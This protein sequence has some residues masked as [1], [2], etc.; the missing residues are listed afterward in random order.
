MSQEPVRK[1]FLKEFK[2]ISHGLSTYEDLNL[3]VSHLAEGTTRTFEAI[4]CCIMLF[5]DTEN[6]LFPFGC[7]GI[8]EK[9]LEK[10]P[11]CVDDKYSAFVRGEPVF[12]EDIRS[13]P[14]IKYPDEALEE[15]IV[16]ILSIPIKF[17]GT[18]IGLIRIYNGEPK[19][20][21]EEDVDALRVLSEHLALVIEYNGLKNF[22]DKVKMAM[23]GLPARM[24][25]G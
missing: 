3:L 24:L 19:R 18:A 25:E 9:Y 7:F 6:Q 11:L 22:F 4:G 20:F 13:D 23:D 15:G 10:G 5:D 21:N 12:I 17:R 2:A 1:F 8:S 14:R 16:S